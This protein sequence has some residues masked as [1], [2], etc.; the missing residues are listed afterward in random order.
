VVVS[1]FLGDIGGFCDGGDIAMALDAEADHRFASPGDAVDDA[2]GPA[3]LDAD[4]DDGGDVRVRAGA[5]QGAEM[6]LEVLAELQTAI[7][8]RDR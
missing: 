3:I 1:E 5:D 7:G 2:L 6:D 8:V 4:D